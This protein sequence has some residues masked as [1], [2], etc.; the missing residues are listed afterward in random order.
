MEV[1]EEV[2]DVL[3]EAKDDK[4]KKETEKKDDKTSGSDKKTEDKS[5]KKNEQSEKSVDKKDDDKK[6]EKK[7]EPEP[8]FEILQNPVRVMRQ[9]LKVISV[10]EGQCYVP[11]KDVTIGGIIVL[12]HTGKTEQEL[13][14]P[15]SA[16]GPKNEDVK[17]P[18]APEP[19]EY[20]ED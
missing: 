8:T 9:Q 15:V 14:E 12:Q 16:Y 2:K 17:E 20:I 5:G 10:P 7:K 11:L 19:F 3:K 6:E 13:V 1:D 4:S 18:E